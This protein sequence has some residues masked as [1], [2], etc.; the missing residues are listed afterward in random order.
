MTTYCFVLQEASIAAA[1]KCPELGC[2]YV[3]A[4]PSLLRTHADVKHRTSD[5][6][7]FMS[8]CHALSR[9]GKRLTTE[10]RVRSLMGTFANSASHLQC[11]I[12]VLKGH[13]VYA[14]IEQGAGRT[15]QEEPPLERR[16]SR[17]KA[18][19]KLKQAG[20]RVHCADNQDLSP[21]AEAYIESLRA[22]DTAADAQ[23]QNQARLFQ[24]YLSWCM[25]QPDSKTPERCVTSKSYPMM[26]LE[27][28]RQCM[29]PFTLR[30]HVFAVSAFLERALVCPILQRFFPPHRSKASLRAAL[31]VWATVRK[32][33]GK[34]ARTDQRLKLS[35]GELPDFP[36]T[37]ILT[38]MVQ[39]RTSGTVKKCLKELA[40]CEDRCLPVSLHPH[41]EV[42]VSFCACIMLLHGARLCAALN[43][44]ISEVLAATD[45][46]G[47]AVIRIA[48]HKT[49]AA[50]GAAVLAL[51]ANQISVL[52]DFALLRRRWTSLGDKL[53]CT[54]SGSEP[55]AAKLFK[56][57]NAYLTAKQGKPY[58]VKFNDMRK[59]LETNL[60]LSAS[61]KSTTQG[62]E[63]VSRY[64]CHGPVTASLHY[65]F[66]TD[67]FAVSG[68]AG[69]ADLV[70]QLAAIQ[71]APS[72][73][74]DTPNGQY[75]MCPH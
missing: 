53:L 70:A 50:E 25:D 59:V 17:K 54:V 55:N 65:R 23:V 15:E 31:D 48:K 72:L 44:T 45:C 38:W 30:N 69:V 67:Q 28:A 6:S 8:E 34:A 1:F 24:R 36:V 51:R 26:F 11:C 9:A 66:K 4:R 39:M 58:S 22:R 19:V 13:L 7:A 20:F 52:K 61:G 21:L 71:L 56:P 46:Q 29:A 35:T 18:L 2:D 73:L 42:I 3:A 60:F 74:P 41:F 68:S 33:T 47:Y 49:A 10:D 43:L 12:S 37:D 63:H 62:N 64:L 27:K 40:A 5:I 57:L 16:R 32:Q 75:I 14:Q